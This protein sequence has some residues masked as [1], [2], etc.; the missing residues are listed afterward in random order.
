MINK[1]WMDKAGWINMGICLNVGE[2][3]YYLAVKFLTLKTPNV[4][5]SSKHA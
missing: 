3:V 2:I 4:F 5:P 1:N